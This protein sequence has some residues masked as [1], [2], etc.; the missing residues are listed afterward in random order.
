ALVLGG[1]L[2][3]GAAGVGGGL[4]LLRPELADALKRRLADG[5][6]GRFVI[7]AAAWDM[8]RERPATGCG[9]DCFRLG[10]GRHRPAAL[11]AAEGPVTPG[12]AHNDFLH[13]LA[14]QGLPGAAALAV[15]GFGLV[16]GGARA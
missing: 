10:F 5:G 4:A 6:A 13:V 9:T 12:K 1:V 2:L 15:L 11:Y 3:L 8:F 16:R 14:T 7:Q